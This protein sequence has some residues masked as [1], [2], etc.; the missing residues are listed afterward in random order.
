[1]DEFRPSAKRPPGHLRITPAKVGMSGQKF[2][3]WTDKNFPR[4]NQSNNRV[5]RGQQYAILVEKNGN[6]A[7]NPAEHIIQQ[8]GVSVLARQRVQFRA[9]RDNLRRAIEEQS[10]MTL[11]PP[12]LPLTAGRRGGGAAASPPA[13]APAAGTKPP[14]VKPDTGR[15]AGPP[16]V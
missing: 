1:M 4:F 15:G 8:P 5:Q 9:I 13:G 14:P 3:A 12:E 10:G 11:L 2:I 16:G 6:P 7:S